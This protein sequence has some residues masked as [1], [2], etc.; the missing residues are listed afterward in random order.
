MGPGRRDLRRPTPGVRPGMGADAGRQ[1][2]GGR[3]ERRPRIPY[4]FADP[5]V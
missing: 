5:R 2:Q 4:K 3:L 1:V